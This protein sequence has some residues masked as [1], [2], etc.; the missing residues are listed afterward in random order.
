MKNILYCG[1]EGIFKGMLT[2]ILSITKRSEPTPLCVYIFT[3]D[4]THLDSRFTPINEKQKEVIEKVVKE[5][6][7]DSKIHLIDVKEYYLKELGGCPNEGAYCSP[8]TLVRC[9]A[10]LIPN[11]PDKLLYLDYDIMFNRDIKLI[12][13]IDINKYEYA[14]APDHYGKY[15]FLH[16][17]G[18]LN[19]GVILFNMVKCRETGLFL[20]ARNQL[21]RK[22]FLFA[23]QTAIVKSTKKRKH[24]P[25]RFNDQKFL[26][27][28]TVIRHFSKRLFWFPYPHTAN[29]KQWDKEKMHKIYKY[30]QWDDVLEEFEKII[31]NMN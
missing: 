18:Y 19:A 24:L 15:A 17:P 9:L 30:H 10:D 14:G 6:H 28:W 7:K 25:Q 20:K 8:Y 31:N 21:R 27:K 13:D 4:L 29:I 22:K 12:Y 2:S 26:H 5:F 1:N 16:H 11:M 3:A 23:D